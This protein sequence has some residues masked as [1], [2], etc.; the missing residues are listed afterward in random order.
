ME[1]NYLVVQN[2][3]KLYYSVRAWRK[4]RILLHEID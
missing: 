2:V 4:N 1:T 3:K